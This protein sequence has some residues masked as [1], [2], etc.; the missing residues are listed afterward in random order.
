M[1]KNVLDQ[2]AKQEILQ[3]IDKLT[4]KTER[5]WGKMNS[6][7]VMRHIRI[8]YQNALGEVLPTPSGGKFKQAFMKLLLLN[9]PAPKGKAQTMPEFDVVANGIDP[10]DFEGERTE[11]KRYIEKFS[12]APT[13]NPTNS[14]GGPF[15][16]EDWGRLMY[17]HTN[18]H[19]SQFGV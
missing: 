3:R 6:S 8:G 13:L 18:H 1:G 2:D 15:T 4:Q 7:Q 12:S 16:R 19:L 10:K 9:M 17:N 11:L 5:K 14:I